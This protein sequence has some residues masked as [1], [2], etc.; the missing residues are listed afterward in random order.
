MER[1]RDSDK[2]S[3][4][5]ADRATPRHDAVEPG[6]VDTRATMPAGTVGVDGAIIVPSSDGT[7]QRID[8]ATF[9]T[10]LREMS[11]STAIDMLGDRA[12]GCSYLEAWFAKHEG[13]DAETLERM[14]RIYGGIRGATTADE[15]MESLRARLRMGIAYWQS[16][17]DV[18]GELALAGMPES[19]RAVAAHDGIPGAIAGDAASAQ[20]VVAELGEGEPLSGIGAIAGTRL[21]TGATAERLANRADAH[22]FTIGTDVVLGA[23]APRPGTL[24][25]DVLL[26]H[27]LA[28]VQQQSAGTKTSAATAD[29]ERDADLA[30]MG[31]LAARLGSAASFGRSML[32]TQLS[33]QRCKKLFGG[34]DEDTA[35]DAGVQVPK[36]G[37]VTDA[38]AGTPKDA[39]V[40]PVVTNWVTTTL[41]KATKSGEVSGK[42]VETVEDA[43]KQFGGNKHNVGVLITEYTK[44]INPTFDPNSIGPKTKFNIPSAIELPD[45]ATRLADD[46]DSN[47]ASPAYWTWKVEESARGAE[48]GR[49]PT[50]PK[51]SSKRPDPNS[52]VTIGHGYDMKARS[53]NEIQADL[54][55]A[56]MSKAD[57]KKYRD[58]SKKKGQDAQDWIDQNTLPA[59]TEAQDKALFL[60]E[61]QHTTDLAVDFIATPTLDGK[62]DR[63]YEQIGSELHLKLDIQHLNPTILAFIVD[64]RFLGNLNKTSWSYIHDAVRT[65]DLDALRVLIK[66]VAKYKANI[67]DNFNRYEARCRML[68]FEPAVDKAGFDAK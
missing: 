50:V 57:A 20:Q 63:G 3:D 19:S 65:N 46:V 61:Y 25:G 53:P 23:D 21:H 35:K 26:A 42:D 68:G 67:H 13:T 55:A 54:E 51:T 9:M 52:G 8:R 41:K 29:T 58:A 44:K 4:R 7:P 14:A 28:H 30:G 1:G 15:L 56:G 24:A 12:H 11:S 34:G 18:S 47:T 37:G 2:G 36:D 66:D 38:D 33:L 5:K 22:A 64:L 62:D 40:P 48:A 43:A 59:L 31:A 39:G 17:E 49:K 16:G 45:N 27:E 10:Q 60:N 6:R 32:S